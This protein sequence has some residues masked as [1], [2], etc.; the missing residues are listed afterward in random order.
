LNNYFLLATPAKAGAYPYRLS[1]IIQITLRVI[2]KMGS[3]LRGN[4]SL[5][6]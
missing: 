4:G 2:K 5:F 6:K 1:T 3:R